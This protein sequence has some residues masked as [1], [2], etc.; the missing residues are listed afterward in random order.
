MK[1]GCKRNFSLAIVEAWRIMGSCC[2]ATSNSPIYKS[3]NDLDTPQMEA[4][5]ENQFTNNSVSSENR[6]LIATPDSEVAS[7]EMVN[8]Y[9]NQSPKEE[10]P[11]SELFISNVRFRKPGSSNGNRPKSFTCNLHDWG[12]Q[13]TS[14]KVKFSP[15]AHGVIFHLAS[16][17]SKLKREHLVRRLDTAN[18]AGLQLRWHELEG[19]DVDEENYV[20]DD[21]SF[22]ITNDKQMLTSRNKSAT[23]TTNISNENSDKISSVVAP[24]A[25]IMGL[26]AMHRRH[27]SNSVSTASGQAINPARLVWYNLSFLLSPLRGS[28]VPILEE[29]ER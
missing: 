2:S 20:A 16:P 19:S 7:A 28:A 11:Y 10:N 9:Y 24:S 14:D 4:F 18:N 23:N 1:T 22:P 8:K 13:V 15:S 25:T 6:V 27:S 3:I 21:E 12:S 29:A 26:S 17:P 5:Y